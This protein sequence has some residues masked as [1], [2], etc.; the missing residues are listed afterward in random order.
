MDAERTERTFLHS[1][2]S[3]TDSNEAWIV[4]GRSLPKGEIVFLSQMLVIF[5][6]VISAIVNIS[7][8]NS[9]ET[10]LML[11]STSLGA[12]LPNLKMK[13]P[14]KKLAGVHPH[15]LRSENSASTGV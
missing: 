14:V 5:I 1:H 3:S 8:G 12:V 10:F 11:L 15:S 4:W 2:S 9:T 7:I 6:I 13:S